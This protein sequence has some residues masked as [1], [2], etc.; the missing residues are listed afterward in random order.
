M[1]VLWYVTRSPRLLKNSNGARA[2]KRRSEQTTLGR[3]DDRTIGRSGDRAAAEEAGE[4]SLD[5]PMY[6]AA[7]RTR[8]V[9]DETLFATTF[10]FP[11]FLL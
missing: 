10:S 9:F 8:V 11:S 1:C 7:D 6:P 5:I 4:K 3:S 2:S